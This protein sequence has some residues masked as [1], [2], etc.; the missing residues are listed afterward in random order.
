VE[1]WNQADGDG[2]FPGGNYTVD[3]ILD[4]VRIDGVDFSDDDRRNN[5]KTN[6][7]HILLK[8]G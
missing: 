3:S 5:L 4:A 1:T 7:I 8:R 6:T 2:I